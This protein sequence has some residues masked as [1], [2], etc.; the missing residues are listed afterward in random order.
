MYV[1]LGTPVSKPLGTVCGQPVLW[2]QTH[3]AFPL[4]FVPSPL[5]EG[6]LMDKAEV[7]SPAP[8]SCPR[9]AGL[10]PVPLTAWGA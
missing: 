8:A 7:L 3:V 1:A 6:I 10:P 9:V 2:L 5:C 4:L